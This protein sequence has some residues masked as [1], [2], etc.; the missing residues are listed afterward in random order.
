MD[1]IYIYMKS[2]FWWNVVL[3]NKIL[4]ACTFQKPF[5]ENTN[6]LLDQ[7]SILQ[8]T[9][10]RIGSVNYPSLWSSCCW[11]PLPCCSGSLESL[12]EVGSQRL[13]ILESSIIRIEPGLTPPPRDHLLVLCRRHR[14]YLCAP[15]QGHVQEAARPGLAPFE[16]TAIRGQCALLMFRPPCWWCGM[17]GSCTVMFTAHPLGRPSGLGAHLQRGANRSMWHCVGKRGLNNAQI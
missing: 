17:M 9:G 1:P 14:V 10:Y 7:P 6:M 15:C 2:N 4:L 5:P 16:L 8:L 11:S 3:K 13:L 12:L